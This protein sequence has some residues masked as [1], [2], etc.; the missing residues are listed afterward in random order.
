MSA[1]AMSRYKSSFQ[2]GA[3]DLI[4]CKLHDFVDTQLCSLPEKL[5]C[6]V[7]VSESVQLNHFGCVC[8]ITNDRD[9][10]KDL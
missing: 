10:D 3:A 6:K 9:T 1:Y 7:P 2:H 5:L 4:F 8:I